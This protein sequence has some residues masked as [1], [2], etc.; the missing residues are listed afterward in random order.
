MEISSHFMV[1]LMVQPGHPWLNMAQ[2]GRSTHR[3]GTFQANLGELGA[4]IE[5]KGE[6]DEKT[7][8]GEIWR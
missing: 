6:A 3:Q 1:Y 5:A 4:K 2:P 7:T 8:T